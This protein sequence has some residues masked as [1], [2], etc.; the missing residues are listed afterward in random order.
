MTKQKS[1]KRRRLTNPLLLS[2]FVKNAPRFASFCSAQAVQGYGGIHLLPPSYLQKMSAVVKEAG[3]VI[4]ADEIQSG[5]GRMGSHFWSYEMS[6]IE[7]DIVCVAKGLS[8]GFPLS[9]VVAKESLFDEYMVSEVR[10][11]SG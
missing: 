6:G 3:G 10:E 4:I 1:A 8:N 7:P 11:V 9:A 5:L 2:C